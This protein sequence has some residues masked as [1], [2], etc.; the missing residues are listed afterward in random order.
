[1]LV[2]GV[3]VFAALCFVVMRIAGLIAEAAA[4]CSGDDIYDDMPPM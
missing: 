2:L 4:K 3:A 1:M